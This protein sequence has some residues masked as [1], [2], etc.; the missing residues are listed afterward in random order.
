VAGLAT[1]LV[2][3]GKTAVRAPAFTVT[4]AFTWAAAGLLLLKVT[5]APPVDAAPL[6]V[7]VPLAAVRPVTLVGVIATEDTVTFDLGLTVRIADRFTPKFPVIVTFV[8]LD[9]VPVV[10]LNVAL[11]A[12][13]ATATLPG[14]WAAAAVSLVN[15]TVTP[16]AGAGPLKVTVAVAELPPVRLVGFIE[17]D[18]SD[19]V[20]GLP[21]NRARTFR[22][23]CCAGALTAGAVWL[24]ASSPQLHG[25]VPAAKTVAPL[26]AV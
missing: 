3:T 1:V 25:I 18:D 12:P 2:V 6:N 7:T 15:P 5:V 17:T 26:A 8:M 19:K 14:T 4:L 16:P 9:T 20:A 11:E 21:M 10:T 22:V 13:A 23:I 24:K